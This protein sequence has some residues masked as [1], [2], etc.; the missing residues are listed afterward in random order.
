MTSRLKMVQYSKH[1]WDLQ[2]PKGTVIAG[3]LTINTIYEAR[4]FVEAYISGQPGWSYVILPM[5]EPGK[6]KGKTND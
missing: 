3:D 1:K 4:M 5:K 6:E 2:S